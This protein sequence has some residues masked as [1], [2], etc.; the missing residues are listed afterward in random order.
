MMMCCRSSAPS[1]T[2]NLPPLP[3][4]PANVSSA[5]TSLL[6]ALPAPG[7]VASFLLSL[8]LIPAAR[9]LALRSGRFAE[10]VPPVG[11]TVFAITAALGVSLTS[12]SLSPSVVTGAVAV[13]LIG[14]FDDLSA[15]SARGK[16]IL[17]IVALAVSVWL[18]DPLQWTGNATMDAVIHV[19]W[20]LWMC[21]AF[22]VLDAVDGLTGGVAVI[23]LGCLAIIGF[24]MDLPGLPTLC[25]LL[26]AS[27]AAYLFYNFYPARVY[28]GDTGSLL[29]GFVMGE[30]AIQVAFRVGG[31]HGI[32]TGLLLVAVPCFEALFLIL[33]RLA[34]AVIPSVSTYDHPTQRLIHSGIPLKWAVLRMYVLAASLAVGGILGWVSGDLVALWAF[35]IG[36]ILLVITGI[37]ISRVDMSGDGLDGRPGS[38]FDKNWLVHRILR[39][40]VIE[41]AQHARG[42]L[43]DVG[44]GSRPYESALIRQVDLYVG[45]DLNPGRYAHGKVD[46]VSDSERLPVASESADMVL[47]NQVIEHLREP[48]EAL[49]EMS[50]ILKSGG[51]AIV[52]APHIWG[53]H[54]EPEDYFRFTPYGLRHLAEKAGFQVAS[55]EALAGF[56]VTFGSRFCYVLE[57]FDRGPLRPLVGL[58]NYT[59]QAVALVLDHFHR[60]EG[61]AWNHLMIAHKPVDERHPPR[62]TSE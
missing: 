62:M 6:T 25:L 41:V 4:G 5:L 26:A 12:A 19:L 30:A 53:I 61:D 13:W 18:G 55:I 28:M 38:V 39:R 33:I 24:G 60:V 50:R 9:A 15:R 51:T 22:N 7:I 3:D 1:G 11:G 45:I 20:L 21:N 8:I 59:T 2:S 34:K 36:F 46:V 31:V 35:G 27:L 42:V 44:C 52:S 48:G 57:R 54:E 58:L 37:R 17:L 23:S 56:W 40:R 29:I 14:G 32:T 47:S 16:T 10:K 49:R 43:V